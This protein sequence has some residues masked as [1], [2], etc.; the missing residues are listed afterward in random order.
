M[1]CR[2][3]TSVT[4][5]ITTVRVL[6]WATGGLLISFFLFLKLNKTRDSRAREVP[7]FSFTVRV[8]CVCD[9][10][11]CSVNF[12]H[13]A[14]HTRLQYQARPVSVHAHIFTNQ[15]RAGV[16]VGLQMSTEA[17]AATYGFRRTWLDRSFLLGSSKIVSF[18]QLF[19]FNQP[20]S[21]STRTPVVSVHSN[22]WAV[23]L[24]H[25]R[26]ILSS[27]P[28][29]CGGDGEAHLY[30]P[31]SISSGGTY[32]VASLYALIACTKAITNP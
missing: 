4:L 7:I 17:G 26:V 12:V 30:M 24:R 16:I 10:T 14:E 2:V 13:C 23:R 21:N 29:Y 3:K 18:F 9:T 27:R 31:D 32:L 1:F 11:L 6:R 8:C 19:E 5:Y 28:S 20:K 15:S 25:N 22:V